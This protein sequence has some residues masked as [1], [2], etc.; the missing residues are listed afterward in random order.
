MNSA[1]IGTWPRLLPIVKYAI[2]AT[3]SQGS[4][5]IVEEAMRGWLEK[6]GGDDDQTGHRHDC[7]DS[8]VPIRA[9]CGN[10]KIGRAEDVRIGLK[11][12][13]THVV[14]SVCV[15]V[16]GIG[17]VLV[18]LTGRCHYPRRMQDL[19]KLWSILLP[20]SSDYIIGA[21]LTRKDNLSVYD[22]TS[23]YLGLGGAD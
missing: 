22:L 9:M 15:S 19:Y 14:V 2:A 3:R 18:R 11:S 5:D 23:S 1:V 6:A 8:E 4:A 7:T 12:V 20:R 17:K 13:V 16:P 21:S 10:L